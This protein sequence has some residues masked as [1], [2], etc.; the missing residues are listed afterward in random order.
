MKDVH[1]LEDW[2]HTGACCRRLS[3]LPVC[4]YPRWSVCRTRGRILSRNATRGN[5]C[6]RRP[7][8]TR[9]HD[10]RCS[11]P[12]SWHLPSRQRKPPT[13]GVPC[14]RRERSETMRGKGG[15]SGSGRGRGGDG[16]AR[17]VYVYET[18]ALFLA[19]PLAARPV[20]RHAKIVLGDPAEPPPMSF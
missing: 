19:T 9:P 13:L 18:I 4:K 20:A 17:E 2:K 12:A 16:E 6:R 7:P 10:S 1:S 15:L 8:R 3:R 14:A 5:S 11:A